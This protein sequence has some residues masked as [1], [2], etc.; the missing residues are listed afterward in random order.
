MNQLKNLH[1]GSR[2]IVN[3]VQNMLDDGFIGMKNLQHR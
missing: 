2:T 1:S 3:I